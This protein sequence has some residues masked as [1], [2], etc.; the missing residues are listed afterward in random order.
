MRERAREKRTDV[1]CCIPDQPWPEGTTTQVTKFSNIRFGESEAHRGNSCVAMTYCIDM[2]NPILFQRSQPL[3]GSNRVRHSDHTCQSKC[4]AGRMRKPGTHS[5]A[6]VK[7]QSK[8]CKRH[9]F[10]QT[11]AKVNQM[12]NSYVPL[13]FADR[14]SCFFP[15]KSVLPYM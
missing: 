7:H 12:M 14:D 9:C 10:Q 2:Y 11:R 15:Q 1:C 13:S 4:L 6:N 5:A 3:T 8:Q